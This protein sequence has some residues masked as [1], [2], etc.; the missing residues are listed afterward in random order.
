MKIIVKSKGH[1][2]FLP[3]PTAFLTSRSMARLWL[4]MMRR[5]EKYMELPE[6]AGA[7][8]WD[9]PEESVLRL[10]DA[11][12]SV[13]RRHRKWDLVEVESASGDRVLIQL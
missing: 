12:R 4:R 8:L 9:L 10:C 3:I 1:R 6:Q 13:K 2:F 5:S 11:L 7:A